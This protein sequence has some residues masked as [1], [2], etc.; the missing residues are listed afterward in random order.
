MKVKSHAVVENPHVNRLSVG[1]AWVILVEWGEPEQG[2]CVMGPYKTHAEA[3]FACTENEAW[4]EQFAVPDFEDDD[5]M[6]VTDDVTFRVLACGE[7]SLT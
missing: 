2:V 3:I 5:L 7:P 4:L 6:V 1:G